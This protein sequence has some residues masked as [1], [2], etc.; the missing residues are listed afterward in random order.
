MSLATTI[1]PL[2]I[3]YSTIASPVPDAAPVTKK[4]L[5]QLIP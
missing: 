2:A 5:S 4:T 1:A 3:A